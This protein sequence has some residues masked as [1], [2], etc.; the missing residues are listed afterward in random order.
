[1][2]KVDFSVPNSF[3]MSCWAKMPSYHKLWGGPSSNSVPFRGI[4]RIL[5]FVVQKRF[6]NDLTW[7]YFIFVADA[8][9]NVRGEVFVMW[10]NLRGGEI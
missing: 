8:A 6:A 10:R 9:D 5:R 2:N 1:M 7:A 4:N 3:F